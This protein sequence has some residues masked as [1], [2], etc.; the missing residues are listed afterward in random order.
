MSE[1]HAERPLKVFLASLACYALFAIMNVF[2]KLASQT[3]PVLQIMFFRNALAL[4]PT[5]AV[6]MNSGGLKLLKTKNP[7]GHFLRGLVG[8]VSMVFSFISFARLP[9]ANATAIQATSPLL[10]TLLSIWLLRETVGQHRMSAVMVGLCAVLFMLHPSGGG[11]FSDSL[12]ALMAAI[13]SAFVMIIIRKIGRTENPIT[14]VFYFM[15]FGALSSALFLP[16]VW[17]MPAPLTLLYLLMVGLTGGSA[18]IFM[19]WAYAN[20]PTAFVSLFSYIS[21]VFAALADWLV[22]QHVI[23]W[24]IALG[25][26]IVVMSGMYVLYREALHHRTPSPESVTLNE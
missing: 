21:I 24:H 3:Q 15:L 4:I 20:A 26:A 16:F 2:V 7:G 23:D 1:L 25:S 5:I 17:V 18:Q 19:T 6:V 14:I 10:Q 13:L 8:A 12:M 9:L 11:H 22:W